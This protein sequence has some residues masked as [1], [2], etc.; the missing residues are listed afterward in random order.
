MHW[1]SRGRCFTVCKVL[2]S[3]QLKTVWGLVFC[4]ELIN[5]FDNFKHHLLC[6]SDFVLKLF[7]PMILPVVP[8]PWGT[9]ARVPPLLQ[10]VGTRNWPNSSDHHESAHHKT[11]NCAFR[12]NKWR[13]T[14][15][16]KKFF[17]ALRRIGAPPFLWT[18]S[19][20]FQIRHWILL[21]LALCS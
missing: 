13:D 15:K 5:S 2:W 12:A 11:T 20:H 3:Y 10:M 21:L 6:N 7:F 14:T 19:P 9:G 1:C 16:T 18:G 17:G 4:Y 8:A